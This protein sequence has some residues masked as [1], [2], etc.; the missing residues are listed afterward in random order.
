[1]KKK[2]RLR[3]LVFTALK[4]GQD[5]PWMKELE[6]KVKWSMLL[7]VEWSV[8][9]IL[10]EERDVLLSFFFC[11]ILRLISWVIVKAHLDFQ[12]SSIDWSKIKLKKED[13]IARF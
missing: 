6:N 11:V 5:L 2:I 8:G 10:I 9:A 1:M 3:Q 13:K 4:R 7:S 12:I